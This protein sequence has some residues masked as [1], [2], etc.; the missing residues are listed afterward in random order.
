MTTHRVVAP[1]EWLRERLELL[2]K[3]KEFT[4]LRDE[5]SRARRGLAWERVD[6]HYV[7]DTADGERTLGDLFDGRHQLLVY[8][9]MFGPDWD[10]GC[11]SCS[12]WADNYER[13]ALHLAQRD[14]TLVAVS[15]APLDKL[16]AY[17]RRMGWSFNWVSSLRTDFNQDYHVSFSSTELQSGQVYYNYHKTSFPSEEAP[18]VSVFYRDDD[19]HVFHTYS[20]FGRGLDMLNAAYHCMDLTPKG[21]DEDSLDFPMSWVRRRDEYER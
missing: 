13:N 6:K 18:G 8:H 2:E 9:F 12:F 5:L 20:T 1:D 14:I 4:R 19:G 15:R 10:A 7:F 3:E 21:R 17:K 16:E 11:P